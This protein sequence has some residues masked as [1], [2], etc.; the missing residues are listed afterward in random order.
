[1]LHAGRPALRRDLGAELAVAFTAHTHTHLN[2]KEQCKQERDSQRKQVN[3]CRAEEG[4]IVLVSNRRPT[5]PH[6]LTTT[7]SYLYT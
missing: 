3:D 2:S 1:M 4:Q 5:S 6:A 7:H